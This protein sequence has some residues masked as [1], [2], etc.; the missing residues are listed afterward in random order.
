MLAYQ[1]RAWPNTKPYCHFSYL[2]ST[3]GIVRL[4]EADHATLRFSIFSP[5]CCAPGARAPPS[6]LTR[7]LDKH[8]AV[9]FIAELWVL[10][11]RLSLDQG[12]NLP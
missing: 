7:H 4:L 6:L 12:M 3:W 8:I 10:A 2:D 1:L 9:M 5:F 11:E